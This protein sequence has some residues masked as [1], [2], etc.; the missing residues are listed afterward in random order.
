MERA[1]SAKSRRPLTWDRNEASANI[2]KRVNVS[3]ERKGNGAAP[4]QVHGC[5]PHPVEISILGC[6]PYPGEIS[7]LGSIIPSRGGEIRQAGLECRNKQQQRDRRGGSSSAAF[8]HCPI[9][10]MKKV[11]RE[12][13]RAQQED[14]SLS[15]FPPHPPLINWFFFPL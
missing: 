13:E 6:V 7:I 14:K 12:R 10:R 1:R 4:S 8:H 5:V 3:G 9:G 15:C 2:P 11:E